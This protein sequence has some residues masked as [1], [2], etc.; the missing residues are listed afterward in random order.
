[1]KNVI[2]LNLKGLH[3]AIYDFVIPDKLQKIGYRQGLY[4]LY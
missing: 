1:M 3:F 4:T 2:I